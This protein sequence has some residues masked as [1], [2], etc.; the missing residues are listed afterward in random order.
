[1]M[2]I[3]I[4]GTSGKAAWEEA[5]IDDFL[6]ELVT[7]KYFENRDRIQE[8]FVAPGL[9]RGNIGNFLRTAATFAHQALVHVDQNLYTLDNVEEA[10]CRHAELT[11]EIAN[12]FEAKFNPKKPNLKEYEKCK[13]R[14]IKRIRDLDTGHALN[15]MRR[16]NVLTQALHFVE[17]TLKTNFYRNNKSALAY[18]IDP[19]YLDHTP[20]TRREKFPELP[21]GI[22]FVQGMNFISFQIRFK[23]L[24]RGGLRT[25]FPKEM[26]DLEVSRDTIF[27]ECYNLSYTQ[28]KKNKD[29]PEGGSK[30]VILLEP[31]KHLDFESEIYANELKYADYTRECIEEVIACYRKDRKD[32]YLYHAQRSFVHS[33]MTLINCD[34]DGK[35]RAKDIIDYYDRPEYIYLGPD[36]NMHNSMIEWIAAFSVGVDYKLGTAFISSKPKAG[37]NHKEFG[38]TSL[39][40]HVCM[41]ECLSYLD[42]DPETENFS[43]KMTGGPDGDVAGNMIFNLHK[44]YPKTAKLIALIDGSGTI[45][46]PK[47]LDLDILTDLF[48]DGKP[49]NAYPPEE[50]SDGGFLLDNWSKKQESSYKQSTLLWKKEKGKLSEEWITSNKANHL[51]RMNVHET[52]AD[53]FIPAGGRPRTLNES[54]IDDFMGPKGLPTAKIIVEGANLYLTPQARKILTDRGTVIIKDSS[55]NKGG[56]ICSSLE[57]LSNLA[58]GDEDFIDNKQELMEEILAIIAE[59]ARDEAML[60]LRSHCETEASLIDISDWVSEKINR[61]TYEILD[62]LAPIKLPND[63]KNPLINALLNYCPPLLR[64]DYV[65]ELLQNVPDIHKKAIIACFIGAK[66]VY[67]R[68][69]SWSPSIADIL[70]LIVSD[71]NIQDPTLEL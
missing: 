65:E 41:E 66:M 48:R 54:N 71:P 64:H 70:P 40:V 13:K 49:I 18:R 50:L 29:I 23:D 14:I 30:G 2:S 52:P 20:L 53:V 61:F 21:Y 55:A 37:V 68:G 16:K 62:A 56:V 12:A 8:T 43:V 51:L 69:L 31:Y 10:L 5:D 59:K 47:G 35:L 15:D 36:E 67:T 33:L 22:F 11:V 60:L 1:M 19:A 7:L 17:Y 4:T 28:Q 24:S 9:V 46:D 26:E 6:K 45:R 32:Q 57:V 25:I 42:I 39:G 27:T 58:L 63:P 44:H 34:D 3:G 38:V